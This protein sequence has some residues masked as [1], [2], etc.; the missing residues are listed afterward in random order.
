L[1]KKTKIN[2]NIFFTFNNFLFLF[3]KRKI[4]ISNK[5]FSMALS[6]K[7]E[8]RKMINDLMNEYREINKNFKPFDVYISNTNSVCLYTTCD[9]ESLPINIANFIEYLK[10]IDIKV[11]TNNCSDVAYSVDYEIYF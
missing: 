9:D 10:S 5:N 11:H 1:Y 4:S 3:K 6:S 7:A 2:T 8:R